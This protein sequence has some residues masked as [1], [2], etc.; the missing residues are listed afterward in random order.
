MAEAA[1]V[2]RA[3]ELKRILNFHNHRYYVLDD[4]EIQ[5][6]EYDLLMRELRGL[7]EQYPE[8]LSADSPTQRTGGPP[9]PAFTQVRHQRPML[10]LANAFDFEELAAWHRRTG[11]T[12]GQCGFRDGLR[13]QDRWP[14]RELDLS[15]R[16]IHPR[17]HPRRRDRGRRSHSRTSGP[18]APSLFP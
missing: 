3:D 5:D 6:H 8:L 13:A 1:A 9:S 17:S 15:R 18:F 2:Q 11:R 7:E 14:R 10:S 12:V 4:P 16:R